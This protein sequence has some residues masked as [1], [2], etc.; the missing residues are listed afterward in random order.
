MSFKCLTETI[1]FHELLR[2]VYIHTKDKQTITCKNVH[3]IILLTGAI[4]T[5]TTTI[6]SA[7]PPPLLQERTCND[8]RCILSPLGMSCWEHM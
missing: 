5:S 4:L 7:P 8:S 2:Y 3:Q 1:Y 6:T